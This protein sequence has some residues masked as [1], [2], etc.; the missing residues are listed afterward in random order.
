MKGE[1]ATHRCCC[2]ALGC[3][4]HARTDSR[5]IKMIYWLLSHLLLVTDSAAIKHLLL[6][7]TAAS[8]CPFTVSLPSGRLDHSNDKQTKKILALPVFLLTSVSVTRPS[9]RNSFKE[10]SCNLIPCKTNWLTPPCLH[11]WVIYLYQN[12]KLRNAALPSVHSS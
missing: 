8:C 9:P 3:D 2:T 4:S 7:S 1:E 6:C 5:V 12:I 10:N 11:V